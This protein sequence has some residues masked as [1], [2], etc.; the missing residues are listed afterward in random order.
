[1][2]QIDKM[3]YPE[4]SYKVCGLCFYI[5][6][7]LGRY[8]NEKQYG[9]ALEVAFDEAGI[10]HKREKRL[11]ASFVGEKSYRNIPDFIIE[12]KLIVDLKAKTI[13]TK[14]DYFQ[15]RRYLV[16][17]KKRLGLIINFRQKYLRPKRILNKFA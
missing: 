16:S 3:I 5:H 10:I 12:D 6:N 1:M 11:P 9:D 2:P 7:R 13:I 4:L 14:D 17:Y 15:M 8:R